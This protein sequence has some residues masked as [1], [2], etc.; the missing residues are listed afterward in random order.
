MLKR[1]TPSFR[2]ARSPFEKTSEVS[3]YNKRMNVVKLGFSC[4][5]SQSFINGVAIA[6]TKV[7]EKK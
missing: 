4:V 1:H 5:F 7:L 2:S 6:R 3:G